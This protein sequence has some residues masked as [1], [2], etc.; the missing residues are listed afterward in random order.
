MKLKLS[1]RKAIWAYVFLAL[2]LLFYL[3]IRIFPTLQAFQMSLYDWH[4]Q[5]DQRSFVGLANYTRMLSD[6]RLLQAFRNMLWYGL[7]G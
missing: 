2:P 3:G 1:T 5:A 7:L 4:V 6:Q